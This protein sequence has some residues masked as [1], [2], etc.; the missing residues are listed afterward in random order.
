MGF[1]G[2]V[3]ATVCMEHKRRP[4]NRIC[5]FGRQTLFFTPEAAL[6][7]VRYYGVLQRPEIKVEDIP[8][9]DVTTAS[10]G[11]KYIR[12]DAF[13]NL[14]G[15]KFT[16]IDVSAYEGADKI[17]NLNMPISKDDHGIA[18]MIIDG[19]TIDNVFNPAQALQNMGAILTER[20]RYI[21][22]NVT[23]LHCTPYLAPTPQWFFDYFV[24]NGW[25]DCQVIL[26]V[27]DNAGGYNSLML[28]PMQ[29]T[30][31]PNVPVFPITTQQIGIYAF[32]E[33]R[34][35][36]TTHKIPNQQHYRSDAEWNEF[37]VNLQRIRASDRSPLLPST[38]PKFI[39]IPF[40]WRLV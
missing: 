39:D 3:A 24:F 35:E 20:G 13:W 4:V 8:V 19:S 10:T 18:D 14:M 32:A 22:V 34:I 31:G 25:A 5:S 7:M 12:D 23:S 27:F 2:T 6:N 15:M 26:L 36:S 40:G 28:D 17:I 30:P 37:M 11:G 33:K 38:V 16:C 1:G 21:G 29:I 9:D